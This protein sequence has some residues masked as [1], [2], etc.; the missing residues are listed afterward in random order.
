[1]RSSASHSESDIDAIL[2][3]MSI[4]QKVGQCFTYLWSGHLIT[5]SIVASIEKLHA[6]GLRLQPAFLAGKRHQYYAFDTAAGA[7]D[8][9]RSEQNNTA[10]VQKILQR[11]AKVVLVANTPY[12]M[13]MTPGAHATLCTFASTPE[14][15]RAA[16]AALFGNIQPGGQ[17]PLKRFACG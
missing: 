5:P 1:M 6:G 14:S 11:G 7:Y 2:K 17:W 13:S 3:Q 16:A 10:L 15:H 9:C 8:Y 12:P 4:E